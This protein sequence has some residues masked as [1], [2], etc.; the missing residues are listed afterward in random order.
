MIS[1]I[2]TAISNNCSFRNCFK[3]KN[4]NS[5]TVINNDVYNYTSVNIASKLAIPEIAPIKL[6]ENLNNISGER[7]YNSDGKLIE[8][9]DNN[10]KHSLNYLIND[11][12]IYYAKI[13]DKTNNIIAEQFNFDDNTMTV[14]ATF[15]DGL[16]YETD[17]Q[18][19]KPIAKSKSLVKDNQESSIYYDSEIK[20]YCISE[21][22]DNTYKV[23]VFD[24]NKKCKDLRESSNGINKSV[25]FYNGVPYSVTVISEKPIP[26]NIKTDK[27]NLENLEPAPR[28]N[29]NYDKIAALNGEKRYY[30]N[31]KLETLVTEDGV[32]YKFDTNGVL[33]QISDKNRTINFG[34]SYQKISELLNEDTSKETYYCE[35]IITVNI[36]NNNNERYAEY[37]PNETIK[38]Y[39]ETTNGEIKL[40]FDFDKNG[41]ITNIYQPNI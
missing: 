7:V 25:S 21:S 6:P 5:D 36:V 13:H 35:N 2:C 30:S 3:A 27:V 34:E 31:G 16:K 15:P 40:G 24:D 22:T 10:F 20:E 33:K 18:D 37:Y 29:I 41:M 9:N 26:N 11:D 14:K 32:S 19:G 39:C 28:Y 1:E 4:N 23:A 8:I 12:K 38:S 17:Y